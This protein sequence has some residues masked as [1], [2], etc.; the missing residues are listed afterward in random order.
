MYE[1][2]IVYT[3]HAALHFLLISTDPSGRL[4]RLRLRLAEFAFEIKYK[5]GKANTQ[6][7]ELLRLNT[8]S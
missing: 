4:I 7:Y 8:M 6:A 5:T 1:V 2:F 3:Y